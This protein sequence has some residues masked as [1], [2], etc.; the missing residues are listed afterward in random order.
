MIHGVCGFA[1]LFLAASFQLML[2]SFASFFAYFS[3]SPSSSEGL[4]EQPFF[5]VGNIIAG[6]EHAALSSK[7]FCCLL[8]LLVV[9]VAYSRTM[10]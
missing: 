2:V 1:L 7:T 3:T 9:E 10:F 5:V 4:G 8:G 6:F